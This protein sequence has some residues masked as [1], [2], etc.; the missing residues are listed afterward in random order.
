MEDQPE[1]KTERLTLHPFNSSDA[2][3]VGR[4]AGLKEVATEA[5]QRLIDFGF[6][7]LN[8]HRIEARHFSAIPPQAG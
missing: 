2:P 8:L 1:L 5:S 4:L 6:E 7:Y 3:D